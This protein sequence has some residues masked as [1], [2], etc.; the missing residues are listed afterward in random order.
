MIWGNLYEEHNGPTLFFW[1][2][3]LFFLICPSSNVHRTV[4]LPKESREG[5]KTNGT[6]PPSLYPPPYYGVLGAYC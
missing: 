4:I 6:P 3:L 2:F 1:P 5:G